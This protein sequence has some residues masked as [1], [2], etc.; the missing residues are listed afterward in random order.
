MV[1]K[2]TTE[3]PGIFA[4]NMSVDGDPDPSPIHLDFRPVLQI[5][6]DAGIDGAKLDKW[7]VDLNEANREVVSRLELTSDGAL[8]IIPC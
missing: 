1:A 3:S 8:L 5:L 7:L 2:P 4:K 6:A